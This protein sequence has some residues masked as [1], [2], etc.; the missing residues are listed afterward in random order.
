MPT[1]SEVTRGTPDP[2]MLPGRER[3]EAPGRFRARVRVPGRGAGAA[4]RGC[5]AGPGLWGDP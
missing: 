2:R 5:P 4:E 1:A 3:W